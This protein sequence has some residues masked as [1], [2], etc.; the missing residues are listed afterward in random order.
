[1]RPRRRQP[2]AEKSHHRE[3][4]RRRGEASPPLAW[5]RPMLA[6]LHQ[7]PISHPVRQDCLA[8][9]PCR[10][11]RFKLGNMPPRTPSDRFT[12]GR[13]RGGREAPWM[14][15]A[16]A[17]W[18]ASSCLYAYKVPGPRSPCD[19]SVTVCRQPPRRALIGDGRRT[20]IHRMQRR[21]SSPLHRLAQSLGALPNMEAT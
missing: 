17:H 3:R 5:A 20:P 10:W 7:L 15:W 9:D 18:E 19:W 11:R 12:L 8:A 16:F 6:L 2:E 1:M 4:S 14:W 21:A 13:A